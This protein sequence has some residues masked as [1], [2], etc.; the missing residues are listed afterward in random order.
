MKNI[1]LK[2]EAHNNLDDF[3]VDVATKLDF[4][5]DF[6]HNLKSFTECLE[7]VAGE[8]P[9]TIQWNNYAHARIVFGVSETGV[10]Y[11]PAILNILSETKGVTL[12]LG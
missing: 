5:Q 8:E 2:G 3:F 10:S 4:P 11:L 7:K 1:I 6:E 9:L 12:L